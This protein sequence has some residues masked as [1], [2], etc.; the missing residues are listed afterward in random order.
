MSWILQ[1][2]FLTNMPTG[3]NGSTCDSGHTRTVLD[4]M[5]G[6]WFWD[7]R[8][9][10][11]GYTGRTYPDPGI[12]YPSLATLGTSRVIGRFL[13]AHGRK[14]DTASGGPRFGWA[15]STSG[16]NM[17]VGPYFHQTGLFYHT[18]AAG[19]GASLGVAY[20]ADTDYYFAS[21]LRATG[22]YTFIKGG[23]FTDWT[24]IFWY[25]SGTDS[26]L[27]PNIHF[28][29]SATTNYSYTKLFGLPNTT[30]TPTLLASDSFNRGT[31]NLHNS[32]T[33]GSGD[34]EISGG[35]GLTW[36]VRSGA[37]NTNNNY[38]LATSDSS[39][40]T[41][42]ITRGDITLKGALTG[43]GA[44]FAVKYI[45]ENNYFLV[46]TSVV[47][48]TIKYI[49]KIE[50][51]G[52]T[53]TGGA[54]TVVSGAWMEIRVDSVNRTAD[55]YYNNIFVQQIAINA[56]FDG[57]YICGIIADNNSYVDGF[58]VLQNTGYNSTLDSWIT[59]PSRPTVSL[60]NSLV[61]GGTS[62][63]AQLHFH[64]NAN[65]DDGADSIAT[66][67]GA[68]KS[69]GY[70]VACLTS[71]DY[72][73]ANPGIDD[74]SFIFMPGVEETT[75]EV[76]PSHV[77]NINADNN[78]AGASRQTTVTGVNNETNAIASM[79]HPNYSGAP[80]SFAQM[81][82]VTGYLL[83]EIWNAKSEQLESH[84]DASDKI[85]FALSRGK[86]IFLT[87]VD[88]YHK[89]ADNIFNTAWDIVYAPSLSIANI[90]AA[91]RAG[92]FYGSRGPAVTVTTSVADITVSCPDSANIVF[93]GY[94]GVSASGP[95][96]TLKTENGVTS[97]TYTCTGNEIYVR[98]KVTRVS[99]SKP[100]WTQPV[101]VMMTAAPTYSKTLSGGLFDYPA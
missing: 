70:N 11:Y 77:G 9:Y 35:S 28:A 44:G 83:S 18:T 81:V 62:Y 80:V 73:Q 60:T 88:D 39:K 68:Y 61:G 100:V 76:P 4:T 101:W 10:G 1:D 48:N 22:N 59:L 8:A 55:V 24:L 71:H 49:Q 12:W 46:W 94:G 5:A 42:P 96:T 43:G 53:V 66:V 54:I 52:S 97:S 69:A 50:G 51:G 64:C 74:G 27:Y 82:A 20:S 89:T 29:N 33:D 34:A 92:N 15:T 65:G 3:I 87:A 93:Y 79:N 78:I 30:F 98:A 14:R 58:V 17:V 32:Q 99:D 86:Q 2:T 23:A 37:F 67:V 57:T 45:D 26:T 36:T 95:G 47:S 75:N 13:V 21:V 6:L 16:D 19:V 40:A 56:A 41:I 91:Y 7:R 25:Q 31:G 38:A 85:D 72:K 63:K 84:G 90:I